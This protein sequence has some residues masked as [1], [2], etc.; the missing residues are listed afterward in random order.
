M[1]RKLN[2]AVDG[3]HRSVKD[4]AAEALKAIGSS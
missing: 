1:M 4:V 3:E 2:Q